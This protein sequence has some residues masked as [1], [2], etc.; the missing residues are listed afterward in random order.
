LE[1]TAAEDQYVRFE[2]LVPVNVNNT[3]FWNAMASS[4]VDRYQLFGRNCV[5][6]V[7]DVMFYKTLIVTLSLMFIKCAD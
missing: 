4:L 7:H 1:T 3:G 6:I 2:V 5:F